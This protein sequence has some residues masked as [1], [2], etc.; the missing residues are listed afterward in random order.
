MR[1]V[2]ET[3]PASSIS[4]EFAPTVQRPLPQKA[5]L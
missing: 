1:L 2:I 5:K 4:R 3:A